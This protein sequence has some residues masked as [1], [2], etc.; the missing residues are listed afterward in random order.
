MNYSKPIN[1]SRLG[2]RLLGSFSILLASFLYFFLVIF[3]MDKLIYKL[4]KTDKKNIKASDIDYFEYFNIFDSIK[5]KYQS[6][7]DR[8]DAVDG[9][10][11]AMRVDDYLFEEGGDEESAIKDLVRVCA[12]YP[13]SDGPFYYGMKLTFEISR[14]S[15]FY[16]KLR[17]CLP[18]IS[19][20]EI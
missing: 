2:R 11:M 8:A 20:L 1:E 14:C 18:K 10:F 15:N 17:R 5:S 16:E 19:H 9:A 13:N 12:C 7:E 3:F 4:M 6:P